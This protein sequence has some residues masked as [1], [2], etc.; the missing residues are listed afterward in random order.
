MKK[1]FIAIFAIA[2]VLMGLMGTGCKRQ[3]WS[4]KID[5]GNWV[6]LKTSRGEVI[7]DGPSEFVDDEYELDALNESEFD[8]IWNH[9][10]NDFDKVA[11]GACKFNE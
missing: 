5:L 4:T 3:I 1:F 6:M 10:K 7:Y 9:D 8:W 11:R 2:I